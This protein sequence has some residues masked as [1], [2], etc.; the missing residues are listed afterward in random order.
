MGWDGIIG[1]LAI[2]EEK[3]LQTEQKLPKMK[4]KGKKKPINYQ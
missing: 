1:R 4:H 3:D 2:A